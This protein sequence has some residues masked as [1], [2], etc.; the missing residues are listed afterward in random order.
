MAKDINPRRIDVVDV[1]LIGGVENHHLEL[2]GYDDRWPAVF[3]D[4][5]DR[6]RGRFQVLSLLLSTSDQP[7]FRGSRRSRSST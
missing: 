1:E 3:R 5:Q 7:Q 4:H 2:V 6:I